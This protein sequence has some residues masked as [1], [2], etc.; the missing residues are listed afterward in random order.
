MVEKSNA[1]GLEEEAVRTALLGC[2]GELLAILDGGG[3]AFFTMIG[4]VEI[5]EARRT[6]LEDARRQAK[7]CLCTFSLEEGRKILL[8][9]YSALQNFAMQRASETVVKALS[10]E[11]DKP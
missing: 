8:Y 4:E 3:I 9:A 10:L 11:I 7:G 5:F 1:T 2:Y 6:M